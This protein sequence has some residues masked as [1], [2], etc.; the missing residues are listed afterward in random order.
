MKTGNRF[1]TSCT[2][3]VRLSSLNT[4]SNPERWKV[5]VRGFETG[6]SAKAWRV[7]HGFA[8]ALTRMRSVLI[9]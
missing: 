7:A 2:T 1:E 4:N 9:V 6:E 8:L 5:V 3:G